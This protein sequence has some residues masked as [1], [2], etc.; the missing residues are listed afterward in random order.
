MM[1]FW[2][3]EFIGRRL[4]GRWRESVELLLRKERVIL[5]IERVKLQGLG[6][7]ALALSRANPSAGL[8]IGA[9]R[10]NAAEIAGKES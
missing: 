4:N 2:S 8:L 10:G 3:Y 5:T 1:S 6:I 7:R 9:M